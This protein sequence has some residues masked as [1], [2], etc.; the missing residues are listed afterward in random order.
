MDLTSIR[1]RKALELR[2]KRE[3]RAFLRPA[4]SFE[5]TA[6]SIEDP[7]DPPPHWE[8]VL[9]GSKGTAA[10]DLG[11]RRP[12]RSRREKPH[13]NRPRWGFS[14]F[15][16]LPQRFRLFFAYGRGASIDNP[17]AVGAYMLLLYAAGIPARQRFLMFDPDANLPRLNRNMVYLGVAAASSLPCDLPDRVTLFVKH[18][19]IHPFL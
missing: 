5:R 14:T 8:I 16:P 13:R 19:D 9:A 11:F 6:K 12:F 18:P 2:F 15:P 7:E 4:R 10:L 17:A 1:N 3:T